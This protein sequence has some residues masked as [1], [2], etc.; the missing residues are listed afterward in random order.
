[1]P[2]SRANVVSSFTI[3]KGSLIDETKQIFAVWDESASKRAN[4]DRVR[5]GEVIGGTEAWLRDV[6]KVINR[7][8]DPKGRDRALVMLAKAGCELPI[9][10]PILLWHLT[11]DE[12]LFHDFLVHFLYPLYSSGAHR[13]ATKEVSEFIETIKSR[14][15]Q[16][17]HEWTDRTRERVAVGLLRM[18]VDFDLVVGTVNREL[19]SYHL[20]DDAFLYILHAIVERESNARRALESHEWRMYLMSNADVEREI[21]RLHQFRRLEFHVAGTLGQLTLPCSSAEQFAERMVA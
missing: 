5:A 7:R 8:F 20:P 10:K 3:V 1:M 18:A 14:G 6:A 11:R 21:F 9:W 2:A 13:V 15:G 19:T 16:T 4:L 12:F 17:E